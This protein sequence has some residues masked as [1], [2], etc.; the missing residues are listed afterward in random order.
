MPTE[1][2]APC[3]ELNLQRGKDEVTALGLVGTREPTATKLL[4][5]D[6]DYTPA[7][8]LGSLGSAGGVGG[9]TLLQQARASR[10]F[11]CAGN[12]E[13]TV[14]SLYRQIPCRNL[15]QN[16]QHLLTIAAARAPGTQDSFERATESSFYPLCPQLLPCP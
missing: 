10:A 1:S 13:D 16:P 5:S 11:S 9:G 12:L 7:L 3:Q 2:S 4:G 8:L 15:V 6:T 14:I